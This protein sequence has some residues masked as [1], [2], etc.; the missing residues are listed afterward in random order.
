MR[1]EVSVSSDVERRDVA[2]AEGRAKATKWTA[3]SEKPRAPPSTRPMTGRKMVCLVVVLSTTALPCRRESRSTLPPSSSSSSSYF[4][5]SGEGAGRARASG[6]ASERGV[7]DEI[8]LRGAQPD[9]TKRRGGACPTLGPIG[10]RIDATRLTYLRLQ[11]QDLSSFASA[12]GH[13]SSQSV[14]GISSHYVGK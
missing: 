9:L 4:R 12:S 11:V 13:R 6:S 14:F 5:G 7:V 1:R 10:G 8:C 3:E 2:R